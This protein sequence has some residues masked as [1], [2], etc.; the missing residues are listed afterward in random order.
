MASAANANAPAN[1]HALDPERHELAHARCT[2]GSREHVPSGRSSAALLARGCPARRSSPGGV[3]HICA[4]LPG[5]PAGARSCRARSGLPRRWFSA[6]AVRTSRR[7]V[8]SQPAR[9]RPPAPSPRRAHTAPPPR[10]SNP[11]SSTPRARC[12]A[13]GERSRRPQRGRRR[14][15]PRGPPRQARRSP[16]RAY[17][18]ARVPPRARSRSRVVPGSRQ[19]RCS[20]W[21]ALE[22]RA[23]ATAEPSRHPTRCRAAVDAPAGAAPESGRGV[24]VSVDAFSLPAASSRLADRS[25]LADDLHNSAPEGVKFTQRARQRRR[26]RSKAV[27]LVDFEAGFFSCR[28]FGERQ[29]RFDR[30]LDVLQPQRALVAVV[31]RWSAGPRSPESR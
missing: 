13:P 2:A 5:R 16:R 4:R 9:R 25:C 24:A 10:R 22:S 17:G 15:S 21:R 18:R 8:P 1:R 29:Q 26:E 3:E 11:R 28:L 14:S 30:L 27:G 12:R 20:W 19:S 31:V 23:T 6:R 7:P